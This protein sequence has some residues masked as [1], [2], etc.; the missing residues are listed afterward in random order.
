[1]KNIL[2]YSHDFNLCYSLLMYLQESYS[3]T[4]TTNLKAIN[5]FA[6][7]SNFDVII[8][9]DTPNN[10]IICMVKKIKEKKPN[11]PV[12]LTYVFDKKIQDLETSLRKYVNSIF[13]KPYDLNEVTMK[14]ASLMI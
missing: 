14:M 11:T 7:A 9:D 1:M 10:D 13:Y 8:I 2:F 3:V 5:S 12:I 4:A 6:E